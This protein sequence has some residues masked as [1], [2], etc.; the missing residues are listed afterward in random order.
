MD[1]FVTELAQLPE[2]RQK[3][4]KEGLQ[5]K[6]IAQA[7]FVRDEQPTRFVAYIEKEIEDADAS[8][9]KMVQESSYDGAI[10]SNISEVFV[11][12]KER[13]RAL[14]RLKD[15]FLQ[16]QPEQTAEP[17]QKPKPKGRP[18]KT[19]TDCLNGQTEKEKEDLLIRLHNVID[20]KKGKYVSL[21]ILTAIEL[22]WLEKPT[23]TQVKDEFGDIGVQ[24][25]FTKYLDK[26]MFSKDEIEGA[27]NSL[28]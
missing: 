12:N 9:L 20:G 2:E 7:E 6:I 4:I 26:S 3:A 11:W 28:K 23:Y 22:G 18:K 1:K 5:N 25:G 14:V 10:L 24:Q 8:M 15:A 19:F 16:P 17:E 27:K 13:K 21:Y